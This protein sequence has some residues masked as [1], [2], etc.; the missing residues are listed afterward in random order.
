MI[1]ANIDV[2]I[3][4]VSMITALWT[5]AAFVK[6]ARANMFGDAASILCVWSICSFFMTALMLCKI[7]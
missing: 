5:S 2:I 7:N 3:L 6:R 1:D 4:W